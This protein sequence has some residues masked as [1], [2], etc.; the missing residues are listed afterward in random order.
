MEH[1]FFLA[2]KILAE[3]NNKKRAAPSHEGLGGSDK[4]TWQ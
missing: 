4:A 1:V 2:E 3:K